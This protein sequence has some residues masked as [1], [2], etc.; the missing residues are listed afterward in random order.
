MAYCERLQCEWS[1]WSAVSPDT[2]ELRMPDGN[3]PDMSGCIAVAEFL[4][5]GVN[6]I[7]TYSDRMRDTKYLKRADGTWSASRPGAAGSGA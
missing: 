1:S 4:M 6:A 5:P 2:L 7:Y 3:A